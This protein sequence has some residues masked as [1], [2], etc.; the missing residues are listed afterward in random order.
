M[1]SEARLRVGPVSGGAMSP[2]HVFAAVAALVALTPSISAAST[3]GVLGP[4]RASHGDTAVTP[5]VPEV[6]SGDTWLRHLEEDLLPYW[7][8]PDAFG[9]PLGNFPSFRDGQGILDPAR[10]TSRGVSTLARGVYGYSVAFHLTGHERYLTYARAGLEWLEAKG[11]DHVRNGWYRD[12]KET[13]DPLDAEAPKQLFDLA[14]VGM[15][16][17]MYFN[18]TRDPWAEAGLLRVRDLVFDRYRVP[19]S[20]AF[21]DARTAD[22]SEAVDL[23]NN[24][25]DI[26]NLLVPGTALLLPYADLLAEQA[27]RDQFRTDLRVVTQALIDQ[28]RHQT[29]PNTWWFWGRTARRIHT[30]AQTDFGHNIKSHELVHNANL[31]FA[32]RP[33]NDLDDDR[34]VLLAKAWDDT[35]ARW[36][37]DLVNFNGGVELDSQ[38]WVH[39][40]ADQTLAA[41]DLREEFARS[42]WLARSAQ[43]WFDSFVDPDF[44]H[45]TW[46]R[47]FRDGTFPQPGG[48][49]KSGRGKNMYHAFEHALVMYLHGRAMEG[50]AAELHY[51]L[52]EATALTAE[53][54][55]YWFDA[56][57]EHR[58]V[59]APVAGL[60]G[61][62]HVTVELSGLDTVPDPLFPPPDDPVPPITSGTLS[63]AANDVGWNASPVVLTLTGR[64]AVAGVREVRAQVQPM[65]GGA[66]DEAW[67]APGGELTIPFAEQGDYVVTFGSVDRLGN[68]ESAQTIR[69]RVDVTPPTVSGLPA[70]SCQIWPPNKRMVQVAEVEGED[71]FSGVAAVDV[72]V[73][74]DEEAA[75]D[76]EID[77]GVV[78]VRAIRDN[79]GDGRVYTVTAR[80]TDV[81]GNVMTR[82]GTCVVPHDRRR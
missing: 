19:V 80:V 12:L 69:V 33:W 5:D 51:A 23:G 8:L 26:T 11:Q 74:V 59:G 31:V 7:E 56:T 71:D 13:G 42:G 38:W 10:G 32:D 46:Q 24:G 14:S 67:I 79:E 82:S 78:R 37:D 44:P 25:G 34:D 2:R 81:A 45:E 16:Y 21:L 52:P 72:E 57:T 27:R 36:H 9:K 35:A 58:V 76:V 22:M 66:P 39:A 15:A 4:V 68:T 65:T 64:D 43:R 61:H 47:P 50:L 18:V 48:N 75:G 29:A 60:P 70:Q 53:A 73:T 30:A 40:E 28:H 1:K 54:E 20:G 77:G 17:G 6:L 49:E 3:A 55:P 41:L 63:P 62:R